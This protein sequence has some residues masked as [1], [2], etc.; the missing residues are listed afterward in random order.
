MTITIYGI[1]I[2]GDSEVR[3]VG[4]SQD[5][6]SRMMGHFS[7]AKNMPEPDAKAAWLCDNEENIECFA[8]DTCDCLYDAKRIERA[9]I[10]QYV[11]LGHRLFNKHH[12]PTECW[13]NW[14]GPRRTSEWYSG[15]RNKK[16]EN[17]RLQ[18]TKA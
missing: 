15:L 18:R 8:I 13:I 14:R 5:I 1:R 9:V 12:V 11:G 7:G 10:R 2:A 6:E 3:Y 4:Q 16:R 17:L